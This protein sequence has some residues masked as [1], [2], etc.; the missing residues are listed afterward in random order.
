MAF[1]SEYFALRERLDW[2]LSKLLIV[3]TTPESKRECNANSEGPVL[4]AIQV[5]MN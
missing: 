1:S 2:L 5:F 3:P 4:T